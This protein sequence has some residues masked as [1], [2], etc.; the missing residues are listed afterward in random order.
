[1]PNFESK[2]LKRTFETLSLVDNVR[3]T[4]ERDAVVP[5]G[6]GMKSTGKQAPKD[7]EVA[8]I[9]HEAGEVSIGDLYKNPSAFVGKSIKVRG[10]VVKFHE[11]IMNKNW[12]HIQDGSSYDGLFDLTI[13]T[14]DR[15]NVGE[16]AAFEGVIMLNKDFGAGY[17]YDVIM[18]DAKLLSTVTNQ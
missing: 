11:A 8:V 17:K 12:V 3:T 14:L 4:P 9:A 1:M 16:V 18:E 13:T 10:S 2:E 5:Q 6:M 15:A 7:Y